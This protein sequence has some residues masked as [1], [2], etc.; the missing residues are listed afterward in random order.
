MK[1]QFFPIISIAVIFNSCVKMSISDDIPIESVQ[2]TMTFQSFTNNQDGSN[3]NDRKISIAGSGSVYIDWGN[4]KVIEEH[5]LK[6]DWT[7]FTYTEYPYI[8]PARTIT[9]TVTGVNIRRFDCSKNRLTSLEVNE[10]HTLKELYCKE[11]RLVKIN[12]SNNTAMEK[13]EL[14]T[15]IGSNGSRSLEELN[16]SNTALTTLNCRY[17]ILKT[18]N[19]SNMSK[20]KELDCR[21]NRLTNIDVSNNTVLEKLDFATQTISGNRV[22]EVLNVSNTALKSLNCNSHILNILDVSGIPALIQLECNNN[23]LISLIVSA[24]NTALNKVECKN[25]KLTAD[26]LNS[27]FK[28]LPKNDIPG[29]KKNIYIDNNSVSSKSDYNTSLATG[30]TVT[31]DTVY[32]EGTL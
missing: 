10:N 23:Q 1:K 14:A 24:K 28:A 31:D 30:W 16:V 21:E 25:N 17:H 15:Q 5:K 22:L 7:E 32:S 2:I 4:G 19:V 12:V 3:L 20:L 29:V 26:A 6:S 11:N 18:L 13:I 8:S 27:L 9:I